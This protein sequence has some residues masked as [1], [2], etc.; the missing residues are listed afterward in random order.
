MTDLAAGLTAAELERRLRA[1]EPDALLVP[2]RILRRVIKKDRGLPGPGLQVPHRKSYVI[3]RDALLGIATAGELGVPAG[4]E[5][6]PTVLLFPRPDPGK[7]RRLPPAATLLKYWRLLFHAR[8]HV[9]VAKP[10]GDGPAADAAVRDRVR[11]LDPTAF[12]EAREV[13]RQENFLLPPRDDRRAYEELAAV[14]LELRCFAPHRLT[15]YFPALAASGAADRLLA[16]DVDAAGLFAATRLEGAADPAPAT[17]AAEEG[18]ARTPDDAPPALATRPD[19]AAFKRLTAEAKWAEARGNDVRAAVLRVRAALRAADGGEARAA[20][21]ASV[22][23]LVD[24]LQAALAL[25][26]DEVPAWREELTA[27]L[28]RAAGPWWPRERRLLYDLQKVCIDQERDLYDV[29][30]L[31]WALS[32]GRRPLKRLLPHQRAVNQVRALRAAAGRL[33]AARLPEADRRPLRGLLHGAVARCE[34]R[35][36]DRFRPPLLAALDGVGLRPRSYAERLARDKLVEELLDRV[37]EHG[38]LMMSDLRDALARNRLKLPDLAGPGEFLLGDPLLRADRRLDA[39]LDGVYHRGE[40]YRRWLQRFSSLGFGTAVGRFLTL[41]LV[42]PFGG[43][44]LALEGLQHVVEPI[45]HLVESLES[46]PAVAAAAVAGCLGSPAAPAPLLAAATYAANQPAPVELVHVW[47]L[48]PLGLFLLLLFHVPAFRRQVAGGLLL[49]WRLVRG[50]LYDLPAAFL[51][52]P[53]VRAFF[54]SR[55]Y[56]LTYQYA[57]K[58]LFWSALIGLTV[59]L[60]GAGEVASLA[61]GGAAFVP[62]SL[63]LHSRLGLRLEEACADAAARWWR[64][65]R[66]DVLPG[67]FRLVLD[68]FRRRVEGVERLLYAVDEWLRF[69]GGEGPAA[70]AVKAVLGPVWAGIAY[71]VRFAFN[72]L[73]EPQAN[74]IKHFPVVTVSHKLVLAFVVPP[75]ANL[76]SLT[77]E[78]ALA[79]TT[80]FTIGAGIPGI[81][82]FLVWEFKENWRLYRANQ[83]ATLRP[84]VVGS[85]GE[86]VGRLLRPGFHSGTL[87]K[88]FARLR[89]A[90]G[91]GGGKQ[92]EALHHCR[93]AMRRFVERRLLAVLAGCKAW[94]GAPPLQAGALLLGCNRIRVELKRPGSGA[95]PVFLDLEEHAGRLAVSLEPAPV[96][97]G[98]DGGPPNGWL[99][100]LSAREAPALSDALAGFWKAAGADLVR[101]QVAAL[102]PGGADFFF[103]D[104]RGLVVWTADGGE[105]F[106]DLAESPRLPPHAAGGGPAAGARTLAAD[107]LFFG[108]VEVRWADWVEAWE[109]D[110]AGKGHK[111]LLRGVRLLPSAH[112]GR[113]G[114]R[115]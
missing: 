97:P 24:R 57:L 6:P 98:E 99:D 83:P 12:A 101:E 59:F 14:Y 53:A 22:G 104:H 26:S 17:P 105:V 70:L 7:L 35:M 114:R 13:L 44:F 77:M 43:A 28:G 20:A 32:L 52:L 1:V 15:A 112:R 48:L 21:G 107:R 90:R 45:V 58:P 63:L 115:R 50:L 84:E 64:L 54:G 111:P 33:A 86:T 9:A 8:V 55:A 25:P 87:P 72:L 81:F 40:F 79:A 18:E 10:L 41:Y 23:R 95:R 37:V 68:F 76:L 103:D 102:L 66:V 56:L 46:P 74:P 4:R 85:H 3:G 47:T 73:I 96:P 75:L 5:L 29:D 80:A 92:R 49:L 69:R 2:P 82:G 62:V 88:L 67:L 113:P 108:R 39:A 34:E 38:Y 91:S 27:L 93:V 110:Q 106:Y 94:E 65:F 42:L 71:V 61:A 31:G 89:R 109:H 100:R 60:C 16:E 19:E 78:P 11:R 51:R 36:R 30:A